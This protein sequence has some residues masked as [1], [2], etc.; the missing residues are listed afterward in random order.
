MQQEQNIAAKNL[1]N[2]GNSK[3]MTADTKPEH[4]TSTSRVSPE[5]QEKRLLVKPV[6]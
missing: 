1:P 5:K 3:T 2:T 4:A 6:S